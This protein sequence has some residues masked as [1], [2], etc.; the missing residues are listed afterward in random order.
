MD[1]IKPPALF[2]KTDDKIS[3]FLGGSIEMGKAEDWQQRLINDLADKSYADQL[4][5]YNPRRDDW[6]SSW[7]QDPHEGPFRDQV[8]WE[9]NYQS[10]ADIL[11]YYFCAETVSPITLL[12]FGIHHQDNPIV[13]LDTQYGRYG[14]MVLTC[15]YLGIPFK[16]EWENFVSA[17][18]MRIHSLLS[19]KTA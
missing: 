16:R 12:E 18:D 17:L 19:T 9:L 7:V 2:E 6:D 14:N 1:I 3:I 10:K 5:L 15:E 11:V 8:T 13:G 4:V